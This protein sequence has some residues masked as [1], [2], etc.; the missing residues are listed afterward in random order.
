MRHWEYRVTL[1]G[2][3]TIEGVPQRRALRAT[4]R[5]HRN[6]RVRVSRVRAWW[7]VA[8]LR[9]LNCLR[10]RNQNSEI[11]VRAISRTIIENLVMSVPSIFR[12]KTLVSM[13]HNEV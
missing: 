3:P 4:V 13:T 8:D 12:V 1:I 7:V 5:H 9:L 10:I 11:A 2:A 6:Q